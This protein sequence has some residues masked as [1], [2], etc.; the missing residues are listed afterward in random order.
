M[1]SGDRIPADVR[2]I[3]LTKLQVTEAMLTGESHPVVKNMTPVPPGAPLGDRK[4]IGYSATMVMSGQALGVVVATGDAAEIGKINT[5]VAEQGNVKTN[6]LVQLEM[7]G[8][9]ITVVCLLIAIGAFFLAWKGP[10]QQTVIESIKSAVAIAVAVIPEGLPAVVTIALALSVSYMAKN[11]A[12]IRQLP[13]VETLGSVTVICSDK[14]GTTIGRS[15][16]AGALGVHA[17][18]WAGRA[19]TRRTLTAHFIWRLTTL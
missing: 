18:R 16:R 19:G 6:L 11:N 1:Q 17:G 5:L 10:S 2:F 14:T 4:C 3:E 7:F 9:V 12:I 13:C 15:R 8:R